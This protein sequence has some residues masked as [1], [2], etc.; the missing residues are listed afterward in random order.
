MSAPRVSSSSMDASKPPRRRRPS[1]NTLLGRIHEQ[2][3]LEE[4]H[5]VEGLYRLIDPAIR[6]RREAERDDEPGLTI[7][8]LRNLVEPVETAEVEEVEV[9]EARKVSRRHGGRP[10]ALVRSVVRYTRQASSGRSRTESRTLWVR[11]R[12][13]WYSTALPRSQPDRG[14]LSDRSRDGD[15]DAPG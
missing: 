5:D 7:S 14:S 2:A 6:A 3:S 13:V 1:P 12:G 9:L 8:H 11:D 15:T 10:A 4:R